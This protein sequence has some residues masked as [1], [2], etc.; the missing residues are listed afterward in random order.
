MSYSGLLLSLP[1][2]LYERYTRSWSSVNNSGYKCLNI[3][4]AKPPA[5]VMCTALLR[6]LSERR[7]ESEISLNNGVGICRLLDIIAGVTE[8]TGESGLVGV[9]VVVSGTGS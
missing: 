9:H 6:S 1:P 3:Q 2:P 5:V 8:L 7:T 4:T